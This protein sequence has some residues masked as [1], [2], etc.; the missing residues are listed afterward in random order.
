MDNS[1]ND[2]QVLNFMQITEC[3]DYTKADNY[4]KMANFDL[5]VLTNPI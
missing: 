3:H 1:K 5:E 2:E 4:M